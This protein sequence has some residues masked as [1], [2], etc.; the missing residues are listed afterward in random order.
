MSVWREEMKAYQ[1]ATEASLDRKEPTSVETK[2]VAVHEEVPKEDAA[3]KPVG[4]LRKRHRSRNL[5]AE[6]RQKPKER[7]EGN[8][9]SRRKLAATRRKITRRTGVARRKGHGR[10]GNGQDKVARGTHKGRTFGKKCRPKPES[11]KGIRIQGLKTQLYLRGER[12]SGRIFGKTIGL[13]IVK[14][15]ARSSVGLRKIGRGRP[16]PKR[17]G[18]YSQL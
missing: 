5:P 2:S 9:G 6:R 11:I 13:E 1:E 18:A 16:P 14:Q 10:Q 7:T 3:V 17:K 8:C 12:T 4:G 15:I